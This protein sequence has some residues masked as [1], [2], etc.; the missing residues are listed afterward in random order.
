MHRTHFSSYSIKTYPQCTCSYRS[1]NGFVL[2]FESMFDMDRLLKIKNT[3]SCR[4]SGG[5]LTHS[6]P[7][8]FASRVSMLVALATD[9]CTNT[10]K[11]LA[12]LLMYITHIQF[13]L[14]MSSIS[15]NQL[16]IL[17]LHFLHSFFSM[18]LL[19]PISLHS[20]SVH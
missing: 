12:N 18:T 5:T 15:P 14:L 19:F 20:S 8:L 9:G 2:T 7:S 16:Q 3:L 17:L 6:I 4:F 11:S 1:I 13:G 10:N